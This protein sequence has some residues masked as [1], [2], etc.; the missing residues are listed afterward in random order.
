MVRTALF[1]AVAAVGLALPATATATPPVVY[2]SAPAPVYCPPLPPPPVCQSYTVVYRT[3]GREPWRTYRV[4]ETRYRADRA[5][6]LLRH[7]GFE[8]FVS[9]G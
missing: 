9:V 5:A 1:S 2:Y 7:R 3:C 4:Y 8:V 6:H